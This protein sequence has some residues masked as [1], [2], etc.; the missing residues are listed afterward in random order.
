[1]NQKPKLSSKITF[2]AYVAASIDGR[3]A[4]NSRSVI[5]WTSKED[6]NFFQ[7]SLAKCDAA[8]VG[9]NTYKNAEANLKKRNTI[10]FES[11]ITRPRVVKKVTFLNPQ[12]TNLLKYLKERK[13]KKVAVVGG[14]RV[15]NFCL[16][17]KMLNELYV[18]IEPLVFT[19]GVPMF[20]GDKFKKY[21][22]VLESIKKLNKRGSILLKYKNAS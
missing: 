9:S 22:F 18:T 5:D 12:H 8:L 10:V 14:P 16:E 20:T 19:S 15:Y 17:N 11:K 21:K 2:I 4:E 7:K 13:Y 3:I 1:M 6:W